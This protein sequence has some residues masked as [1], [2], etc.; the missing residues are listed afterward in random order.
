MKHISQLITATVL[1]LLTACKGGLSANQTS[2][3]T[4]SRAPASSVFMTTAN[5]A[6]GMVPLLRYNNHGWHSSY[7][8]YDYDVAAQNQPGF[9]GGLVMVATQGGPGLHAVYECLFDIPP[10][11]GF[12]FLSTDARCEGQQFSQNRPFYLADVPSATMSRP[13]YRCLQPSRLDHVDTTDPNECVAAGYV[14]E[15]VLG[16]G[17]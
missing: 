5:T 1:L 8:Q 12:W 16:F 10:Q 2:G 3:V 17:G 14:V 4:S 7:P 11:Y 6:D 15:G 13:L 9:E